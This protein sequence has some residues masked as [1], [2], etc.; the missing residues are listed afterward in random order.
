M[1]QQELPCPSTPTVYRYIDDDRLELTNS[2]LP[3]KLCRQVKSSRKTHNRLLK[4]GQLP[5]MTGLKLTIGKLKTSLRFNCFSVRG[6][7]NIVM[8]LNIM[9]LVTLGA[10]L[11]IKGSNKWDEKPKFGFSSHLL[12]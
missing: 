2:E 5:L 3:I 9:K 6:F 8:A 10:S 12:I 1:N 11:K 7:E 4:A